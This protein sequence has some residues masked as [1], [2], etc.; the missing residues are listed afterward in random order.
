[1]G[2]PKAAKAEIPQ[3]SVKKG[4]TYGF[5]QFSEPAHAKAAFDDAQNLNI[6]GH[7]STVLY[8]KRSE[9][10]KEIRKKKELK[11]KATL[12]KKKEKGKKQKLEEG[13]DAEKE[14]RKVVKED[15]SDEESDEEQKTEDACEA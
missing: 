3:S 8:A 4:S 6:D 10:L 5:V 1:M 7:H 2:F 11:R 15:S 13:S 9:G 12:D 14:N